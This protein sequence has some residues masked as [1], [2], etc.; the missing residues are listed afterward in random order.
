MKISEIYKTKNAENKT[1]VSLEI[2]PPKTDSGEKTIFDT[3]A[4][5]TKKPNFISVTYRGDSGSRT[6]EIASKI[7]QTSGIEVLHHLTSVQKSRG[8]IAEILNNIEAAG[9]E[10]ILALRGDLPKTS[11]E[12]TEA[13][14]LAK[15]LIHEI[16]ARKCFSV[17]AATYP[18]GHVN[19]PL[20]VE[21]ID[22]IR[23]KYEAGAD[24]FISQLFF[25]NDKFYRLNESIKTAR[26]TSPIV[27]GIMPIMS[28]ANVERLIFFG[29]SIPTTLIKIINKYKDQPESLQKAGLEYAFEQIDDLLK[30]GIDGVHIYTMNRPSVANHAMERYL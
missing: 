6:R 11:A 26:I 24:F 25:D 15:D 7:K 18:E 13:Y 9:I 4:G 17:G 16:K 28:A 2:F 29:A 3:V 27:A 22:H 20:N 21:N 1:V 10:N 19:S 30:H 23:Q 14:P 5:L 12:F 8:D